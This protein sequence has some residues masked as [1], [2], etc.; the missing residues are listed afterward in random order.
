MFKNLNHNWYKT[1]EIE[2][3]IG[4]GDD[5]WGIKSP[6][7]DESSFTDLPYSGTQ[8]TGYACRIRQKL[9]SDRVKIF[10]FLDYENPSSMIGKLAGGHDFAI[11]DDRYIIDPWLTEVESGEFTMENGE[12]LQV[13]QKIFDLQSKKDQELVKLLYGSSSN[14]IRNLDVEKEADYQHS[15]SGKEKYVSKYT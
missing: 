13:N 11:V 14:W 15:D 1:A 12:Q 10:G 5:F 4:K 8:C 6:E 2:D 9:G 3:F 7:D